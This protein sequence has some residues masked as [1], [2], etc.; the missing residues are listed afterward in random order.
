[1]LMPLVLPFLL[2]LLPFLLSSLPLLLSSLSSSLPSLPLLPS[3]PLP[4]S[5]SLPLSS[6]LLLFRLERLELRRQRNSRTRKEA[7]GQLGCVR[8]MRR[9]GDVR[10][11]LCL[12][13]P[14]SFTPTPPEAHCGSPLPS[15]SKPRERRVRGNPECAE[16]QEA[17]K[18]RREGGKAGGVAESQRGVR[19]EC[20][21]DV[22]RVQ[23]RTR[24][25][26]AMVNRAYAV[27]CAKCSVP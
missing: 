9:R 4:S 24:G 18:N 6:S 22:K 2:S 23:R 1:M 26:G 19:P 3:P 8:V 20:P 21:Q 10:A 16:G 25:A 15:L 14:T 11:A 13:Q 27:W 5:S 17:G 7:H 12:F